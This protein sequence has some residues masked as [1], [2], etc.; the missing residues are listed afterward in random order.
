MAPVN[1]LS[2]DLEDWYQLTGSV[3]GRPSLPRP[4]DLERQVRSLLDLFDRHDCRAT[5][6]CLGQSLAHCP[7]II[8]IVAEAGHEIATHGWG[9]ERVYE[10][11]LK[12]FREDLLKSIDWLTGLTGIAVNGYRAPC[13]SIPENQLDGFFDVCLEAGLRYDSSVYPFPGR[14]YGI[15]GAPRKPYIARQHVERQLIEFPMLTVEWMG[16]RWPIAGGGSW[17]LLPVPLI[18]RAISRCNQLGLPAV[19]YFHPYEFD[20]TP[21]SVSK[22]VGSSFRATMWTVHQ[23]LGRAS[24]YRKLDSIMRHFRFGTI[25]EYL[26]QHWTKSDV[27]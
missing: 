16:R 8:S 9:H 26:E 15:S 25:A 27:H 24:V 13:F 12:A 10:I 4:E 17:R 2:V 14:S 3:F 19:V 21:L 18:K 11:G 6:F 1:L 20:S 7:H 22:A 5:F 23:N